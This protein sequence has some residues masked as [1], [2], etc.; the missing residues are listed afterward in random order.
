METQTILR[1]LFPLIPFCK[2]SVFVALQSTVMQ[3]TSEYHKAFLSKNTYSCS[4]GGFRF[5]Q[6]ESDGRLPEPP[7]AGQSLHRVV[8]M[9]DDISRA[10]CSVTKLNGPRSTDLRTRWRS[11]NV[12]RQNGHSQG[13]LGT[14]RRRDAR[15]V[16][17]RPQVPPRKPRRA[18]QD[19]PTASLLSMAIGPVPDSTA[20]PPSCR[21]LIDYSGTTTVTEVG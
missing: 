6:A 18:T 1:R 4:S 16:R 11:T 15:T 19:C 8:A 14:I 17:W 3:I 7:L 2:C 12:D 21:P 9:P 13:W 20:R 10:A 5:A